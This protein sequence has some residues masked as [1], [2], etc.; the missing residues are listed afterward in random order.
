MLR[1]SRAVG[2]PFLLL[3]FLSGSAADAKPV[4]S[5]S[6]PIKNCMVPRGATIVAQDSIVLI[7]TLNGRYVTNPDIKQEWRYCVR[8]KGHRFRVLVDAAAYYGG[9]GDIVDVGPI[10]LAGAYVAYSTETTASGGRGSNP[11][12][13]LYV[14]NLVRG[15]MESEFLDCGLTASWTISFC[16]VG[17]TNYYRAIDSTGPPVLILSSNGLAA[18][19]A[20]QECVYPPGNSWG[21]CAWTVQVLDGHTGW[22][23][24][25]DRLPLN[26]GQYLPDP[27]A[28][29]QLG[30]CVAGCQSPGQITASWTDNGAAKS[31]PVQ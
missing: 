19:D 1:I 3:A 5:K 24:V 23:A 7:I 25:L 28:N 26:Q 21:P 10:T 2:L 22:R 18:W 17:P 15:T 12:G 9:Y 11:V 4:A 30:E 31:A 20:E 29:L 6:A 14:R 27:F 8:G 16:A 13:M